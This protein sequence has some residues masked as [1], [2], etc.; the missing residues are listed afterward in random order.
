MSILKSNNNSN[1]LIHFLELGGLTHL[2]LNV[3]EDIMNST[4]VNPHICCSDPA[5]LFRIYQDTYVDMASFQNTIRSLMTNMLNMNLNHKFENEYIPGKIVGISCKKINLKSGILNLNISWHP[6]WNLK[7]INSN[8]SDVK[9]EILIQKTSSQMG[10]M[11][12]TRKLHHSLELS[13]GEY[14][15]W[16]RC[17]INGIKGPNPREPLLC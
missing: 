4:S 2:P 3:Q 13:I 17:V 12:L 1:Y 14:F 6:P 8:V 7:Y 9:Y 11:T 16:I 5:W 10:N 15:I